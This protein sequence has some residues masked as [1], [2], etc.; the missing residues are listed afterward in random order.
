[1][2][3]PHPPHCSFGL[4]PTSNMEIIQVSGLLKTSASTGIDDINPSIATSTIATPLTSIINSS[5]NW[6]QLSDC[7]KIGK[8]TP[9]F[10]AG[11]NKSITNYRPISVLPF[12][13]RS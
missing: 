9:I 4:M 3:M 13:Q 1:M 8:I 12:S 2:F 7:V 6:G 10:K 5:F 11:D